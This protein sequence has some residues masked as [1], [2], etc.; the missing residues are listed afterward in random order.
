MK[1]WP[2]EDLQR[3]WSR[4]ETSLIL[5]VQILRVSNLYSL[6]LEMLH[7]CYI[8]ATFML[9]S[10]TLKNLNDQSN[11]LANCTGEHIKHIKAQVYQSDT[12]PIL[13]RGALPDRTAE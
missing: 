12:K 9:N 4:I 8:H 3:N 11:L 10:V 13:R 5:S 7:S 2:V 1:R 6:L